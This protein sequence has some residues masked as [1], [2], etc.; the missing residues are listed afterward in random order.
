MPAPVHGDDRGRNERLLA[1]RWPLGSRRVIEITSA[2]DRSLEVPFPCQSLTECEKMCTYVKLV[3]EA[4]RH[5]SLLQQ[6]LV[7][8]C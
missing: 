1:A 4:A 3:S 6:Y 7:G 5:A 2:R 8:V